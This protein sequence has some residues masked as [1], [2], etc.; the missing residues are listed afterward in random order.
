LISTFVSLQLAGVLELQGDQWVE[1]NTRGGA[2]QFDPAFIKAVNTLQRVAGH[3]MAQGEP[4]YRFDFKPIPTPGITDTVLTIDAQK[5]HYYNQRE[6]WQGMIWPSNDPETKGTRLQWQTEQAGTNKNF[7]FGGRWALVRM[8]ERAKVE[9][10]D[11]ATFQLT[12]QAAPDTRMMR[13]AA[14]TLPVVASPTAQ[15]PSHRPA[16]DWNASAQE[17]S[18]SSEHP[19]LDSLVTQEPLTAAPAN[20]T[21]PLSY[22][23]RT[24]VGKGPLELLALKGFVLPNRMFID[25]PAR[26]ANIST[27]ASPPPLPKAAREAA[28]QAVTPLP[29][30][31]Q[32]AAL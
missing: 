31:A 15:K 28:K 10:V 18:A 19:A 17:P 4:Q 12:W 29:D 7:E 14:A 25:K 11:S 27:S 26:V 23:M 22:L 20:L 13:V 3:L 9:P 2:L 8:L 21:Y 1:T 6:T 30:V 32:D 16:D 24:D 5:L